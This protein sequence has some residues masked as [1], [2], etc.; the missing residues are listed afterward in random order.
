[1]VREDE[2]EDKELEEDEREKGGD[3]DREDEGTFT[4]FMNGPRNNEREKD[5]DVDRGGRR[6]RISIEGEEET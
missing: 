3:G 1:M 5:C 6:G 4:C 2:V